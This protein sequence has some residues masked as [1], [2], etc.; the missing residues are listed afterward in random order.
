MRVCLFYVATGV[1]GGEEACEK[2]TFLEK[3][4]WRL[5]V[6]GPAIPSR[7]DLADRD[8]LA[9]CFEGFGPMPH[10]PLAL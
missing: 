10:G 7:R 9:L 3:K 6:C 5:L 2:H 8:F 1:V 4:L